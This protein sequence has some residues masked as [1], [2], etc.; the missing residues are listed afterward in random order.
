MEDM[1]KKVEPSCFKLL[2]RQ[3]LNGMFYLTNDFIAFIIAVFIQTR[4]LKMVH[5]DKY[6]LGF[7]FANLTNISDKS[8]S[9]L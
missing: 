1:P 7:P 2:E 3:M 9:F 6:G 5:R 4:V 8:A